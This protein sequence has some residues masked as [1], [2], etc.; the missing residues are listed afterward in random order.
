MSIVL[1]AAISLGVI[2]AVSSAILYFAAQKFKV[3]E[4]PRIDQVEE[5]LPAANCGGCGFPGCRGFAEALVKA[6]SFDGLNCPVGGADVMAQAA[7][8]L[9]KEP[10]KAD[11]QIAVLRCQGTCE[12]RP[13]T[14]VYDGAGSCAIAAATYGGESGCSFG[15]HGLGDCVDV[16]DFDALYI[17]PE[18]GIPTVVEDN[19]V[20]CGACIKACPTNLFELRKKG[21]KGRRVYVGCRNEDKGAPAKKACSTA[22]IGCSKCEKECKFDAITISNNLAFIDANKCRLCRKCAPVCPTNAI[23]EVNFPPKKIT[24]PAEV[25]T[26]ASN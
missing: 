4:D 8:V 12:N 25:Q 19:C 11:P 5:I 26:E 22:C 9:G 1:I 7:G 20:A 15:C 14:N 24:P 2:G 13:K 18:L 6:E 3:V 21:P 16:C 17:D 10:V 23:I